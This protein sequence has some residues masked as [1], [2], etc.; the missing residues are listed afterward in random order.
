MKGEEQL[1]VMAIMYHGQSWALVPKLFVT[2]ETLQKNC[3]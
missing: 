3:T 2:F 1:L